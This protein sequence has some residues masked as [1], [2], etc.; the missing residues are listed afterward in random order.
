MVT[1]TRVHA[2][3]SDSGTRVQNLYPSQPYDSAMV[4]FIINIGKIQKFYS[5]CSMRHSWEEFSIM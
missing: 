5:S 3:N 1:G 2:G 4:N